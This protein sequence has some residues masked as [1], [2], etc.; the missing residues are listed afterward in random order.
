VSPASESGFGRSHIAETLTNTGR[1]ERSPRAVA[2]GLRLQRE[3]VAAKKMV[4]AAGIEPAS[5][6]FRANM[7]TD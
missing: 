7:G 1:N 4:E 6:L 5:G 2:Y 3:P